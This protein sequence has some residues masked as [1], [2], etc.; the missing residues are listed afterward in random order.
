MITNEIEKQI[1]DIYNQLFENEMSV[2]WFKWQIGRIIIE[3]FEVDG[4][5]G[6]PGDHIVPQITRLLNRKDPKELYKWIRVA[7]LLPTESE[8]RR[9]LGEVWR[10]EHALKLLPRNEPEQY[11]GKEEQLDYLAFLNEFN[12]DNFEEAIQD[13]PQELYEEIVGHLTYIVTKAFELLHNMDAQI[14]FNVP[15]APIEELKYENWTP[16]P[17]EEKKLSKGQ[18]LTI[19]AFFR[20]FPCVQCGAIEDITFHHWPKTK[21]AGGPGW[22]GLPLCPTC[23]SYAQTHPKEF[24]EYQFEPI[25]T[26]A[27][28]NLGRAL[29]SLS[30]V[31]R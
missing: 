25:V 13:C 5:I 17:L 15:Y 21:G 6:K 19:Q 24:I 8:V 23:H 7:R 18:E 20:T 28:G 22:C 2:G 27:I 10:W 30:E 16:G 4:K 9:V 29:L 31:K 1:R 26:W 11:G 14:D 12:M 3:N